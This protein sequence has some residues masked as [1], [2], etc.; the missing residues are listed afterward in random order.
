MTIGSSIKRSA[1]LRP[2]F[3]IIS[4]IVEHLIPNERHLGSRACMFRGAPIAPKTLQRVPRAHV[5]R[6]QLVG[7]GGYRSGR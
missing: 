2:E 6:S 4:A 7:R 5:V 1:A 3:S